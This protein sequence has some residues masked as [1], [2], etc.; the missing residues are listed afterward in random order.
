N[1]QRDEIEAVEC[2]RAPRRQLRGGLDDKAP[3][4]RAPARAPRPDVG[5]RGLPAAVI[6]ARS[7][8]EE[9]LLD[10][11]TIQRIDRAKARNVGSATSRPSARTRGRRI[12]TLR[13]PST[14]S[15]GTVPARPAARSS[16]C[17]YRGPQ[18]TVRSASS[19]V[20]T[21]L[22]PEATASSI[23]SAR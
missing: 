5:A 23:S 8:T 2:G 19:I 11:A 15:L 16:W 14:T 4:H 6:L 12:C 7:N 18:R 10:D 22:R 17:W 3:A 9:H 20:V 13:P 21:T 1:Q